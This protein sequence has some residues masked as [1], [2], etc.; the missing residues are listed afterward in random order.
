MRTR[1]VR[2]LSVWR[3]TPNGLS[4]RTRNSRWPSRDTSLTTQ[5]L[6][7]LILS[8]IFPTSATLTPN[9]RQLFPDQNHCTLQES[10]EC[11]ES[12]RIG[13]T[14]SHT[15]RSPT[16]PTNRYRTRAIMPHL[17][18]SIAPAVPRPPFARDAALVLRSTSRPTI[19]PNPSLAVVRR[20]LNAQVDPQGIEP[21]LTRPADC[22]PPVEGTN[23]SARRCSAARKTLRR[24][25]AA[26]VSTP[27][28]GTPA[29]PLPITP[30][31]RHLFL[32]AGLRLNPQSFALIGHQVPYPVKEPPHDH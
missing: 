4:C 10:C 32:A 30:D 13:S 19:H 26:E 27:S 2:W 20:D 23:A 21:R 31:G 24:A 17:I 6:F 5:C 3:G 12:P 8:F 11:R 28:P 16:R 22:N 18:L 15:Y 9:G 29:G 14:D 1:L 25:P 7:R